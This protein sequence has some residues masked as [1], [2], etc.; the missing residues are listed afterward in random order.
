MA[1]GGNELMDLGHVKV[2][3]PV[4][5]IIAIYRGASH[6]F[7]FSQFYS[8]PFHQ[9]SFRSNWKRVCNHEVD[10]KAGCIKQIEVISVW[11][12]YKLTPEK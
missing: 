11:N 8:R 7:H 4:I 3:K 2:N 5:A 12:I 9:T 1:S 6:Y 10:E